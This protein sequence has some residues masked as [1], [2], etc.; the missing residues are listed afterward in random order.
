MGEHI[1]KLGSHDEEIEFWDKTSIEDLSP[2][3]VEEVEIQRP[4]GP[5][6]STFAVR[7]DEKTV[8]FLREVAA[9]YE[10]GPTQLVRTWI[11][12]R[13]VV[14]RE[15]GVLAEHKSRFSRH[16]EI[17]LRKKIVEELMRSLPAVADSALQE[18]DESA[19]QDMMEQADV[20]TIAAPLLLT[21]DDEELAEA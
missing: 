21:D 7:L 3:A 17:M 8:Q 4:P 12:E 1:P 13:I 10:L 16:M 11:L 2:D 6:S 15:A 18:V 19:V 20:E 9:K 5:L 14:E